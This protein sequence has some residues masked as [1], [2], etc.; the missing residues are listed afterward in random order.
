MRKQRLG[1]RGKETAISGSVDK[2]EGE[3]KGSVSSKETRS[4]IHI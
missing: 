2:R 4:N 1:E 3:H